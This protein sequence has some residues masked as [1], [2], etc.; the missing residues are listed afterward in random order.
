VASPIFYRDPEGST[1]AA[2]LGGR[3]DLFKNLWIGQS[4]WNWVQYPIIR[5]DLSTINNRTS[6]MFENALIAE[7]N[8]IALHHQCT[9]TGVTSSDYLSSL[10]DHLSRDKRVVVL[11]DE[12]DKPILD[13]LNDDLIAA[14]NREI[15]RQF[16]A[17]LKAR[18]ADLQF[19][20]LTGVT[21]FSK[22]SVFSG[23]NN[24]KDISLYKKYS[25]LLGLMEEEISHY[26]SE[27][28]ERIAL[29]NGESCENLREKLKKWYN[30][31]CFSQ[32][33]D[34]QRVYNPL[35]VMNFLD[36]AIQ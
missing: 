20:F 27:D 4:N 21:K 3:H 22:V 32:A 33:S 28:L 36:T 26:F 18:D 1:L 16:Y 34:T 17:I 35:S 23:L 31:Y 9:L 5:L 12:Y 25:T 15:L 29:E 8:K 19:V 7:L 6:E 14:E 13:H 30:G 24:L 11:V 2:L 10:I